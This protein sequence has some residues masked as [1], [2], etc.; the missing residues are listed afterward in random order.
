M[1]ISRDLNPLK[2]DMNS[3]PATKIVELSEATAR[4]CELILLIHTVNGSANIR[5]ISKDS[6]NP[7]PINVV[8]KKQNNTVCP[9]EL[10]ISIECVATLN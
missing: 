2:I 3:E 1:N 5:I 6:S 4:K 9:K 8:H 10:S 7:D